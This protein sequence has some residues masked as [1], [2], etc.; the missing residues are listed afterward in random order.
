MVVDPAPDK[1]SGRRARI[2]R[3]RERIQLPWESKGWYTDSQEAARTPELDTALGRKHTTIPGTLGSR[4]RPG[5]A[6]NP[7]MNNPYVNIAL[8]PVF[9]WAVWFVFGKLQDDLVPAILAASFLG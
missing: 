1:A 8:A 3:R 5:M 2:A 9:V 6:I 7:A 4:N